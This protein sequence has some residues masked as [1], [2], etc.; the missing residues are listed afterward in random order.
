MKKVN[1]INEVY[2][3][4]LLF[5]FIGSSLYFTI[6]PDG[7]NHLI[8]LLFNQ[9]ILFLPT[10]LYIWTRKIP[11]SDMFR[12]RKLKFGTIIALV[13]F[14]YL[15]MPVMHLINL[16][17]LLFSKNMI[18]SSMS[19][20]IT[21]Q[22]LIVSIAAI[23]LIPACLEE[24]V[25]RGTFLSTYSKVSRKRGILLSS[26]LF[27][28]L[29]LNFNQFSYAFIMG[30]IFSLLVEGTDSLFASIIVH[31][32]INGSNAVMLYWSA[33]AE[34]VKEGAATE[35]IANTL[36]KK[37]IMGSLPV[38]SLRALCYGALAYTTFLFIIKNEG[39]FISISHI[40]NEQT[41]SNLEENTNE[42]VKSLLT[43]PL[44]LAIVVCLA[45][46]TYVE[47]KLK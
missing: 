22:P 31:F 36:T 45:Y 2:L 40:L 24:C 43:P 30:M 4:T 47:L 3:V 46:M 21:K 39:K 33:L 9:V 32:V 5:S 38:Y 13:A 17:S 41:H 35:N 19:T 11:I 12:F 27:G 7:G 28:L 10:L 15:I 25:Y 23:A 26:L 18:G 20:I 37:E 14:S 34:K 44:V 29:H 8:S 6:F 16:I 1:E 42:G